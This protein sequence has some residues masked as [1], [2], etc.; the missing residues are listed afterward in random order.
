LPST[1]TQGALLV[2]WCVMLSQISQIAYLSADCVLLVMCTAMYRA[3]TL[4]ARLVARS[5]TWMYSCSRRYQLLGGVDR[6]LFAHTNYLWTYLL[7]SGGARFASQYVGE[8]TRPAWQGL[9][10]PSSLA[11]VQVCILPF[12]CSVGVLE[13]AGSVSGWQLELGLVIQLECAISRA[14]LVSPLNKIGSLHS[15]ILFRNIQCGYL[16]HTLPGLPGLLPGN[17]LC[18]WKS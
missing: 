13:G 16:F 15:C 5:H 18:V 7:L 4:H 3:S 10:S 6:L 2:W 12:C 17:S 14:P 1:P 8:Q 9:P 11:P